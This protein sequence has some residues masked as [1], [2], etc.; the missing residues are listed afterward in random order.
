MDQTQEATEKNKKNNLNRLHPNVKMKQK[1]HAV[2]S[3]DTPSSSTIP[4]GRFR[5]LLAGINK[6]ES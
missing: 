2:H 1:Q 6:N 4:S 3:A 5:A